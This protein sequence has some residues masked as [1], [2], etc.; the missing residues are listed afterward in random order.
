[1][2]PMT[3]TNTL[4][5]KDK[6]IMIN[7]GKSYLEG[8]KNKFNKLD[9]DKIEKYKN[10]ISLINYDYEHYEMPN[11]SNV[12][13][14]LIEASK[15]LFNIMIMQNMKFNEKIGIK[16]FNKFFVLDFQNYLFEITTN[17]KELESKKI[18]LLTLDERLLEKILLGPRFA[19]WNNADIGSH[20]RYTRLNIDKYNYKLFNMLSYMHT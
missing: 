5:I 11:Q 14:L 15:K 9:Y 6:L 2:V 13:K 7:Y 3:T 18:T 1:M 17:S 4:A 19:H 16:F 10:E 8:E 12:E 20:I